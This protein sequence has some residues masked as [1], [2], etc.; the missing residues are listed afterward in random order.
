MRHCQLMKV[1]MKTVLLI[2][3]VVIASLRLAFGTCALKQYTLFAYY[4][5]N[6][7]YIERCKVKLYACRGDCHNTYSFHPH[8][9]GDYSTATLNCGWVY[10]TCE[11]Q[12]HSSQT[13]DLY[14]CSPVDSSQQTQFDPLNPWTVV[15]NDA[16][17]CY[18]S[19]EVV[20]DGS[21]DCTL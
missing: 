2:V 11:V 5:P 13:A 7:G 6:G 3:I 1:D 10:R 17:S 8:K 15:T 19:S 12:A 16:T 14:G 21:S 4:Q 18:C 20:G 9:Q